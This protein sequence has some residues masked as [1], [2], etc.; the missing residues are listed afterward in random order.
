MFEHKTPCSN[1]ELYVQT[2]NSLFEQTVGTCGKCRFNSM[3]EH[4]VLCSNM[5]FMFEHKPPC[6]N[7]KQSKTNSTE[8]VK[9]VLLVVIIIALTMT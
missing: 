2:Y 1:I 3:F 8:S 7:R 4:G 6:S 9:H 5:S